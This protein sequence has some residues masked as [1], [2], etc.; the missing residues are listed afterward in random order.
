MAN[1]IRVIVL[2]CIEIGEGTIAELM[3]RRVGESAPLAV[4]SENAVVNTKKDNIASLT[5]AGFAQ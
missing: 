3:I 2:S 1:P 4:I 5:I